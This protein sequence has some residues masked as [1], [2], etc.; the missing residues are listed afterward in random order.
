MA[1]RSLGT[2][3]I[4]MVLK[5]FGL[6]QG[7]DKAEREMDAHAKK[8]EAKAYAIGESIG[9]GIKVGIGAAVAAG[10]FFA[11]ITKD[12]I[13]FADQMRDMSIRTGV[14][15]EKLSELAY[16]ARSTG[17]DV[18]TLANGM[19]KLAKSAA[20]GLNGD[21]KKGKLFDALGIGKDDLA[22]LDALIP[23]IA[24]KFAQLP[25]GV[26]KTALAM[27]LFGK[28]GDQLIEFLNQGSQGLGDFGA[29]AKELGIVISGD[30]ASKADQFKDTLDDAVLSVKGLGIALAAEVLPTLIDL[31]NGMM[32]FIAQ[33]GGV[34]GVAKTLVDGFDKVV[35]AVKLAAV[36]L[37]TYF[38]AS[39]AQGAAAAIAAGGAVAVLEG[40][41]VS[42]RVV[43]AAL[44]GP[45]GLIA[46]A[47]TA[48][49]AIATAEDDADKAAKEHAKTLRTLE[50]L[51]KTNAEQSVELARQ[52]RDE[53]KAS[54]DAARASLADANAKLQAA[55]VAAAGTQSSSSVSRFGYITPENQAAQQ[56][57]SEFAAKK[58]LVAE[59]EKELADFQRTLSTAMI[60]D[61]TNKGF[62]AI[63]AQLD[64]SKI[65]SALS[66][67]K[68]P[69]SQKAKGLTDAEKEA[70]RLLQTYNQLTASQA[71]QLALIGKTSEES[72]ML[73]RT[74]EGDLKA[75]ADPLKE[76]LVFGAQLL[77]QRRE[78]QRIYEEGLKLEEDRAKAMSDV[79]AR[80]EGE[81]ETLGM[82]NEELETYYALKRAGIPLHSQEADA[83]REKMA[84]MQ[85]EREQM[86]DSIDVQDA[87]RRSMMD[88][89]E[90]LMT[91]A[92]S[93][94]D[95]IK[96]FFTSFFEQV[97][98][99]MAEK[100]VAQLFGAMG[101]NGGGQAGGWMQAI[102][103][104]FGGGKAVGGSV[105][106][107]KFYEVGEGDRPELLM[108]GGREYMIPGNNGRVV[109][110]AQMPGGGTVNQTFVIQGQMDR[111]TR[112]QTAKDAGRSAQ[113]AMARA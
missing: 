81:R 66:G 39:A 26:T 109:P 61:G 113:R 45:V 62:A 34:S 14:S 75:L 60:T 71:E 87:W 83:I 8:M 38:V 58:R 28:S 103:S 24:D 29:R 70:Q 18:E 100:A 1:S 19:R 107:G 17:A 63:S 35:D 4:D 106:G 52:K 48:L 42:L 68:D 97:T 72:K 86:R 85:E 94:K 32:D 57:E 12:A 108:M 92:K 49:Y 64:P 44:T 104:F 30:L 3:T 54:L 76:R 99:M 51:M 82:T 56:A 11:A 43:L 98:R 93:L 105:T 69:K 90:G 102:G 33:A 37:G 13:D 84:A 23:K 41:L 79:I 20:E 21:S 31:T 47:A 55:R 36:Y 67:E 111:T 59:L 89:F 95:A 110:M 7:M 80:I 15:T 50:G 78:E 65:Q 9:K 6:K 25:D 16:A 88:A 112:F 53:A 101:S 22:D 10:G 27:E 74:Q 91:G 2:L 40:A 46:L 77:D 73:Y 96:D 5:T